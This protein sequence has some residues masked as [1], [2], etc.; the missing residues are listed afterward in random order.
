MSEVAVISRRMESRAET[1]AS[2]LII[3]DEAA[4]RESLETLLDLEGYYTQGAG[5]AEA[6]IALL[7][8]N[9]FD[10]VLLDIGLP[11]R[12]GLDLLQETRGRD[13]GLPIIMITAQGTV[14]N[15]VRAM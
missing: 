5:T 13:P 2:V 3:D 8:S 14:D 9:V 6:G 10:V 1:A 11:D 7:G 4:I 12:S 15:A